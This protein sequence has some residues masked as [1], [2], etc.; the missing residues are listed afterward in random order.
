M[1]LSVGCMK[2]LVC[3]FRGETLEEA[4]EN[5]REAFQLSLEN[6]R[7]RSSE[8]ASSQATREPFVIAA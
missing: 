8:M 1:L 2:C 7:E 3:R 5:L 6:L 4:R